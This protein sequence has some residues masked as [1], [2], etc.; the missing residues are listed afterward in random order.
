MTLIKLS[1]LF[2][3]SDPTFP[4]SLGICVL[5]LGSGRTRKFV[6]ALA[7]DF[8]KTVLGVNRAFVMR[9]LVSYQ[10]TFLGHNLL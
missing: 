5:V 2:S 1:V 10:S 4:M 6:S 9:Y 3:F 8:L 7:R